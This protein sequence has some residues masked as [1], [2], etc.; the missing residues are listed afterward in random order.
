MVNNLKCECN[1]VKNYVKG[2]SNLMSSKKGVASSSSDYIKSKICNTTTCNNCENRDNLLT[3]YNNYAKYKGSLIT[4]DCFI[5][6][7]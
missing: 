2:R 6:S 5:E 3:F 4:N 7:N 1:I